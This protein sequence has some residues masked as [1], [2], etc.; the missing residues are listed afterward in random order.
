MQGAGNAP[1]GWDAAVNMARN[2]IVQAGDPSVNEQEKKEV[3][4]N[5]ELAQTWLNVVTNISARSTS[6]NSWCRSEWIQATVDTWKKIVDP[7]AQRVQGSMANTLPNIPGMDESQLAMLKP[8]LESLK[9]MSAAMFSMQISNGLAALSSEVLCLTDIGIPLGDT[10]TPSLLP[11]NI[12]EFV[13][14]KSISESEFFA[15]IALRESAASRIFSSVS[16]LTPTLLSSIE[17]YCSQISVD[18]GKISEVM[19]QIDPTNP[20]SIQELLSGDFFQIQLSSTQTAALTRIERLLALVEGWILEV[21]NNAAVGRLPSIL[22]LQEIMNRRR[23]EGG[24]AEK[25]F[26]ALIGL[27]LRPKLMREASDFWNRQ[28]IANGIEIRD[29]LWNHPDLLP[30]VEDLQNPDF[31]TTIQTPLDI[32]ALDSAGVAP[33]EPDDQADDGNSSNAS[34]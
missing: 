6:S 9:P 10:S 22:S 34:K 32:S 27:T 13:K 4:A 33:K 29:S 19:S 5:V 11:R 17:E 18:N 2:N 1:V 30:S 25:T 15:Y 24:P 16:W 31:T 20:A 28:T 7:V 14:D 26:G 12:K 21:V 8:L 23:A 3:N